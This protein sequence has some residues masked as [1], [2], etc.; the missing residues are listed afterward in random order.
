LILGVL[1]GMPF[2]QVV[3]LLGTNRN[4]AYKLYHDARRALKRHLAAAGASAKVVRA[5]F[6]T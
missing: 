2:D 1:P 5:A 3:Q 4:S 6:A